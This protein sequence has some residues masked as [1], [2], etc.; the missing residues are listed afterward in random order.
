MLGS[1][2]G[3]HE[4]RDESSG[5]SGGSG[6]S[7]AQQAQQAQQDRRIDIQPAED[8]EGNNN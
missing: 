8:E 7:K 4:E 2:V 5:R 6:G 3:T 1:I